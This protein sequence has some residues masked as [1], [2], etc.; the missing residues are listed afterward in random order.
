MTS[1]AND[2][3]DIEHMPRGGPGAGWLDRALQTDR[4]EY[5]D[6]DDVPDEVKQTVISD[7][8]RSGERFGTHETLARFTMD[9]L[10]DIAEPKIIELGAGHGDLSAHILALH[11]GAKVTVTDIDP[12]SVTK[13]SS[14]PLGRHPRATTQVMDATNI[15]AAEDS[16]DLVVFAAAFHHLP[17]A[18]AARAVAEATR[19][20][21]QFVVIDLMRLPA[22]VM[23]LLLAI[24]LPIMGLVAALFPKR[25]PVMHDGLIS[26]LRMYSKSA[27]IALGR[28][29]GQRISVQFIRLPGRFGVRGMGAV[30][31]RREDS[32][33]A[34]VP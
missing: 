33:P 11:P 5:L 13:M 7:L 3:V 9:L 14:G 12:T 16:Y 28:A 26:L 17:P 24:G 6:R 15:D 1:A 30:V 27:Y 25:R 22:A 20:G 10:G 29:A 2:L 4:L 18:T 8:K 19:V 21:K 34:L 32:G 31:Y 23:L